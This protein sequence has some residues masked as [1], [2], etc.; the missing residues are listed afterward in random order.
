MAE[1]IAS[2]YVEIKYDQVTKA[3]QAI[4]KMG[5][6]FN[7]AAS[8]ID[9][10][11]QKM[12]RA[13]GALGGVIAGIGIAKFGSD[14]IGA[15]T[16][17]DSLNRAMAITEGSAQKASARMKEFVQ[18]AKDPG[19]GLTQLAKGYIQ[20]KSVGIGADLAIKS[21]R[22]IANAIAL[23]GGGK[24]ELERVTRQF[25]Q[26]QGKGKVMAEDLMVIAESMPQIRKMAEQAFPA[27]AKSSKGLTE[28]LQEMGVTGQQFIAGVTAEMEKLP[29]AADGAKNAQD[30]FTDALERFRAK[31]GDQILP[32]VTDL[33]NGLTDL[34]GKFE[35][36]PASTQK[37]LGQAVVGGVGLLGIAAT[38]TSI[39]STIGMVKS[40]LSGLGAVNVAKMGAGVAVAETTQL[41]RPG[42]SALGT[43]LGAGLTA[44]TI[45]ITA[46]VAGLALAIRH[47][48]IEAQKENEI[49]E[50]N[51]QL[52][53]KHPY[54]EITLGVRDYTKWIN[55]NTEAIEKNSKKIQEGTKKPA[56][57]WMG[58]YSSGSYKSTGLL[59]LQQAN[60]DISNTLMSSALKGS[61]FTDIVNEFRFPKEKAEKY[62]ASIVAPTAEETEKLKKEAEKA[63]EYAEAY[64]KFREEVDLLIN[65]RKAMTP[66]DV[67]DYASGRFPR[68]L[69]EYDFPKEPQI[70]SPYHEYTPSMPGGAPI[71]SSFQQNKLGIGGPIYGAYKPVVNP[72]VS[73]L[74][75][76]LEVSKASQEREKSILKI[77]KIEKDVNDKFV[78]DW[79]KGTDQINAVW[80][81]H[82]NDVTYSIDEIGNKWLDTASDIAKQMS[83]PIA[84]KGIDQL[85]GALFDESKLKS[86]WERYQKQY[87]LDS[88]ERIDMGRTES[89]ELMM[90]YE[91]FSDNYKAQQDINKQTWKEF[92]SDM[93]AEWAKML[94]K[95]L[96]MYG[97]EKAGEWAIDKMTKKEDMY[98]MD[99][100][101]VSG[102]LATSNTNLGLS[103]VS[104][105]RPDRS[106]WHKA[107]DKVWGMSADEKAYK[108]AHP[109][110]KSYA[111]G[112][113][114][115]KPTIALMG[116]REPELVIPK[117]K[118]GSSGLGGNTHIEIHNINVPTLDRQAAE[119]LVVWAVE[120][121]RRHNRI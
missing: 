116:E 2:T 29:R 80:N 25:V 47:L 42:V 34:M 70:P 104:D 65:P 52:Y 109:E 84:E 118:L 60:K 46:G 79:Q 103:D 1:P 40:G 62:I 24:E 48:I 32:A 33:L 45:A 13:F 81:D 16:R 14:I 35:A 53:T 114:I 74:G 51:F 3:Q 97:L 120:D 94:A 39:V 87:A 38:L 117:S 58:G 61:T 71:P 72:L 75:L 15:S 91:E 26:M 17:M 69:I 64:A 22:G 121:A 49:Q 86:A 96:V 111:T 44:G 9:S 105:I 90:A 59:P 107:F 56:G 115:M 77:A 28:A 55:E 112:G 54:K 119:N 66:I 37:L 101:L 98:A 63:K 31:L 19:L 67:L 85:T 100:P 41:M 68:S 73:G 4:D 88:Q 95:K 102:D 82:I 76:G 93:L 10:R 12:S 7:K 110:Q 36:M 23:V 8:D 99:S 20:L 21:I 92:L 57:D 18:I 11:T 83:M 113:W 50:K 6:G 43:G 30:N 106:G 108:E 89:K 27:A 78:A 5:A